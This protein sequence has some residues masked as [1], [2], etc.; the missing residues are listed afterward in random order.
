MKRN[1]SKKVFARL[2][3]LLFAMSLICVSFSGTVWAE[4]GGG[5]LAQ[6]KLKALSSEASSDAEESGMHVHADPATFEKNFELS[7]EQ[8]EKTITEMEQV[9]SEIIKPEM[10]DLEKYY[11]LAIW[12]NKRVTYD[13]EFW[14]GAYNF[15]YYSHQW[16]SYG[17]MYEKSVCAG[18]AIFY[19]QLC[20][21]A[22]LP[23]WFVR[24]DPEVLDHTICFIPNINGNAYYI[25]VTENMFFMSEEANPFQPIDKAFS[26]ITNETTGGVTD[27]TDNTFN[28]YESD[29]ESLSMAGIK[30]FWDVSYEGWFR[31]YA[32]HEGTD[33]DFRTPYVEN[34]SGLRPD[35]K[36]YHHVSYHDYRSNF[37]EKPDVWFLDDFYNDSAAIKTK[38]LN[39][40]FDEQL[41]NVSGLKSNYDCTPEE[42]K[43]KVEQDISLRYFP[44]RNESGEVIAK[45]AEL[46]NGTDYEVT[47]DGYDDKNKTAEL[48]IKGKGAYKGTHKIQVKLNSAVVTKAPVRKKGLVYSG[49]PQE[50]VEPGEAEGGE[51]QYALGTKT[52]P[53][54]DFAAAIP[55]ATNAGKYYVWYKVLGAGIHEDTQPECIEKTALISQLQLKMTLKDMTVKVGETALISPKLN[56][57]V[58]AQFK[59]ENMDEEEHT[60]SVNEKGII[61][62]LKEGHAIIYVECVL[63]D[64]TSNY[65]A[66]DGRGLE[67][68]VVSEP[69]GTTLKKPVAAKKAVTV[70]WKKQSGTGEFRTAGYQ[71]QLAT[72]KTF[73]KN[74]KT[75]N[76]NGYK[77]VSKKVKGLKGGKKYYIRIRTYKNVNGTKYYSAWSK[78]KT[79]RTRS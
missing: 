41:L 17:A 29:G 23:C 34:G 57:N 39:K 49:K 79:A 32:L 3:S 75:V 69:K 74:K 61:T 42:L 5:D 13:W 2:F 71:V 40:E 31:E 72:N 22:D 43:G 38:I 24:M 1:R 70:K 8:K 65:E 7:I 63:K 48:T 9:V 14:S 76:V 44:S 64:A 52:E 59:Y 18:I 15:D 56:K 47:Y 77:K 73:T 16:D 62:G 68:T 35:E 37:V 54:G 46:T 21:A 12:A 60:A 66:P 78:V 4:D 55:T 26:H 6:L 10:S 45:A 58:P 36:G 50:L 67:V 27:C 20:H 11:T 53:T 19:A 30:D 51:M 33:K 25:D 28:Y